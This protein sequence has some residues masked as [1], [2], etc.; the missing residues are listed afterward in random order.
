MADDEE[1]DDKRKLSGEDL[2]KDVAGKCSDSVSATG[3]SGQAVSEHVAKKLKAL[4]GNGGLSLVK[5]GGNSGGSKNEAST[6]KSSSAR[7]DYLAELAA[8]KSPRVDKSPVGDGAIASSSS[9]STLAAGKG[10]EMSADNLAAL[11]EYLQTAQMASLT[12]AASSQLAMA[13]LLN[14]P[15]GLGAAQAA[16]MASAAAA[17]TAGKPLAN[18]LSMAMLQQQQQQQ[19]QQQ[20]EQQAQVMSAAMASMIAAS[21]A[22]V[23][24]S[25]VAAAAAATTRPARG[26]GSRGGSLGRPRGSSLVNKLRR[27]DS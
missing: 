9:S 17:S 18:M 13:Q 2:K 20:R 3:I 22:G 24:T 14:M 8:K 16:L 12:Q 10:G 6:S 15:G 5:S 26:R 21:T 19:Q 25:S 7:E 1:Q 4:A 27:M 11:T 23:S